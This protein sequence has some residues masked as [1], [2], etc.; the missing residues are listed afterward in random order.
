MAS[1]ISNQIKPW[2]PDKPASKGATAFHEA[3]VN[4]S[5]LQEAMYELVRI[6]RSK[7]HKDE[8]VV[9]FGAGTGSSAVFLLKY[10]DKSIKLWLVD[11][12]HSWLAKA[13]EILNKNPDVEYFILE[14][15]DNRYATLA[16]TIG[17]SVA[18]H[19]ISA[20]TVH[21][22]PDI[23]EAFTGIAL[24]LKEG[25]TFTFQTANLLREGRP[26]GALMID[27]TVKSVHDIA[28]DIVRTDKNFAQY[29]DRLDER[30]H[31]EEPQR[32]FVFPDPRP[33][34]VYLDALDESGFNCEEPVCI[35]VKIK[36]KDWLN[37]LRVKR[38]QAGILPEIGGRDPSPKEEED[39][40]KL[41][42]IAA[43]KLFK[44]LEEKNQL[45]DDKSFTVESVYISSKKQLT[46]NV[47]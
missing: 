10:M 33:I 32:K 42:T 4:A 9:D 28:L 20:N 16:E 5:W 14:K 6:V 3:V 36:Y 21:L 34:E 44:E 7:I 12:S 25:G 2:R 17:N 13:Y 30:V 43:Q 27:D 23:K 15:K 37:F 40:D 18:D 22:I 11:N 29:L 35:L 47:K 41:I 1:I 19:V 31:S 26:D 38:L 46:K 8:I 24:A 39:R 45:A